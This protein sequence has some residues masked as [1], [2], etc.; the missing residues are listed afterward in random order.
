MIR[1]GIL[2]LVIVGSLSGAANAQIPNITVYG[3]SNFSFQPHCGP[4]GTTYEL[5]VVL[6]NANAVVS[7]VDFTIHYPPIF[8]WIF[9][10]IGDASYTG[11]DK[12]VVTIGN[13]Q[14]GMAMAWHACCMPDGMQGSI[15][16]IRP[17]VIWG[18]CDCNAFGGYVVSVGGYT[19][20]GKTE[21]SFISYPDFQEHTALGMDMWICPGS[22]PVESATWGK[23]KAL[24]R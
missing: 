21:P 4:L 18:P 15:V 9:D 3:D 2:A 22:M 14:G 24:Y 10:Q 11:T 13:S 6:H 12:T 23:V 20:L 16:L 17:V 8:Y 19:P 5:V 1:S 7:A